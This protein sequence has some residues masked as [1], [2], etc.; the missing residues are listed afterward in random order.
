M[1]RT[2]D[3]FATIVAAV[4]EGRIIYGNIR[5]FVAFLLSCNVGEILVIFITS[6]IMGPRY[7][8]L[9]P[10]QLLWLNLVTDS[11]PALALG[12]EKGEPGI[13]NEPPRDPGESIINAA[14]LRTIAVQSI[15]IFTA[16][17]AAFRI[18]MSIFDLPG[19]DPSDHS[20]TFAF[21]TLVC[22]ELIRAFSARSE[23]TSVF[24]IGIFSN[25]F[26]NISVLISAALIIT[27]VYVPFMQKIFGTAP[28]SL[29]HWGII[30]SLS[31]IPFAAAEIQ[32]TVTHLIRKRKK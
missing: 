11:F 31:F 16:V 26:L 23:N 20:R 25:R 12:R 8:P 4:R 18:G 17:F 13:M 29:E 9:I 6:I 5:K 7:V 1:R 27:V 2:D 28:I 32:K 19:A 14:M 21:V 15:A 3:N 22:A 10:I 30:L 24:R